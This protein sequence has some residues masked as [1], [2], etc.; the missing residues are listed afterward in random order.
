MGDILPQTGEI[1]HGTNLA[2]AYFDQ[3]RQT[4]NPDKSVWEN[5]VSG[6]KDTVTVNG[7][8]RHV[9]SYLQDFLFTSDRAKCP[10]SQLSGGE[11]NRLLLARLFTRPA[12]VLVFDEPTNDLD[13][14]TLELLE[15][16]LA[17]FNGTAIIVS[18][19]RQFI[20]NVVTSSLAFEGDGT[21]KEYVGDY[22][23][24]LRQKNSQA[25]FIKTEPETKKIRFPEPLVGPIETKKLTHKEK[26][27]LESLPS[28]IESKEKEREKL[29]LQMADPSF[30]TI[31][32]FVNETKKQID[33]IEMELDDIYRRWESLDSRSS[34]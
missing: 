31:P 17:D 19:D 10:V 29:N 26:R 12:N 23:Y 25:N 18:H 32:G 13:T 4:L 8:S 2:V 14:E 21:F 9:F 5:L 6:G 28:L 27:E 15:D 33:A 16:L 22:D 7:S 34:F 3:L 1:I 20:N 30:Y 24:W 11:R